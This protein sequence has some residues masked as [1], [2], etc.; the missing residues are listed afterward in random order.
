MKYN[1]L[2]D[3]I[4]KGEKV[5]Y[6][7]STT[8]SYSEQI[9]FVNTV[10]NAV[11]NESYMPLLEDVMFRY[12][13]VALFTNIDVN[14]FN[15]DDKLDIDLFEEFDKETKVSE[16][17][18]NLIDYD[19]IVSLKDSVNTNIIYKTGINKDSVSNAVAILLNSLTE[20]IKSWD[21]INETVIREFISKFDMNSVQKNIV[22]EY[23]KSD[24]YADN[25]RKVISEKDKQIKELKKKNNRI[26]AEN[27]IADKRADTKKSE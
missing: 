11:V 19:L 17:L 3:Y 25:T 9:V 22:T 16:D 15:T 18:M 14:A 7:Y 27:V 13:L 2:S 26:S 5:E 4:Y 1:L 10:S 8:A 21:G 6:Y 12:A 23:L 24:E 20:R